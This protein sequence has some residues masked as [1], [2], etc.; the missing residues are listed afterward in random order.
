MIKKGKLQICSLS[1]LT[2]LIVLDLPI[3]ETFAE[4]QTR[5]QKYNMKNGN[6]FKLKNLI[7]LQTKC[8]DKLNNKDF[9]EAFDKTLNNFK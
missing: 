4:I 1:Y 5:F 8:I 7:L 6:Y 2:F 3:E 9:L